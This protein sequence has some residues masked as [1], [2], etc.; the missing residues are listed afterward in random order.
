MRLAD[1]IPS[2]TAPAT[3]RR[4]ALGAVGDWLHGGLKADGLHEACALAPGDAPAALAFLLLV[5]QCKRRMGM[6]PALI[7]AREAGAP[8]LPYGPGLVELGLDPAAITLL[9]LPDAL[10]VLRAGLDALRH[11]GASVLIDLPARQRHYDLTASRRLALAAG[12]SG[13]LALV[14]RHGASGSSVAHT[15]WGVAPA[16]SAALEAEA[17]GHTAFALTLL[18]QRGGR[19]G[20]TT[21][22]EWNRDDA[23]FR[24]LLSG[25]PDAP[26]R[27]PPLF[28]A[29]YAQASGRAGGA[30]RAGPG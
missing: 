6:A 3:T 23:A 2:P 10:S 25:S 14:L 4:I 29:V 7:W 5:A 26:A 21:T 19:E 11:G 22:L 8:G 18:R 20:M 13:A 1:T 27:K 12:E 16:P 30:G 15:R 28:G 9:M 17:P 24:P